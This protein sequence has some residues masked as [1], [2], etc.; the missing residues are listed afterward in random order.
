MAQDFDHSKDFAT[1]GR[2][3]NHLVHL[4][5][6]GFHWEEMH[7]KKIDGGRYYLSGKVRDY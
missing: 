1:V 2:L 6:G 5:D 7:V 4:R 3:I